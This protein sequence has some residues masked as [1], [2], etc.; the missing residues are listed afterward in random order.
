MFDCARANSDDHFGAWRPA[1][2]SR[3]S[4]SSIAA[5]R[6]NPQDKM[7]GNGKMKTYIL[8]ECFESTCRPASVWR[9]KEQFSDGVG[10]AAAGS[11]PLKSGMHKQISDQQLKPQA[12]AS[13]TTRRPPKKAIWYRADLRR[14]VHFATSA[15]EVRPVGGPSRLF[16]SA[17]AIEWDEAF[18]TMNDPSGRAVGVHQ[19]A[20]SAQQTGGETQNG[21]SGV[22]FLC[23][24]YTAEKR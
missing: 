6:I 17:K 19:S 4:S 12:S 23:R 10:F 13:R 11:I 14:A 7:C 20:L 3:Q 9:Q 1:C 21:P 22:R 8:R 5:M 2:R 15:A 24:I 16:S 18:K